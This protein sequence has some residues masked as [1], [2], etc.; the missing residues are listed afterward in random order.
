M[1][2]RLKTA[3]VS[4]IATL[5]LSS[6]ILFDGA[7]LAQF[8][9]HSDLASLVEHHAVSDPA[10]FIIDK[11]CANRIVMIA[12]GGHGDV[13]YDKVVV[14]ALNDWCSKFETAGKDRPKAL[15]TKLIL[16]LEMDSIRTSALYKYF[17]DGNPIET[18]EPMNLWGG[19]FTTSTLEFYSDLRA[20]KH[21]VEAFNAVYCTDAP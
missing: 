21:R 3:T 15:P 1:Q 4:R 6:C 7:L 17:L 5:V 12:D 13:P 16:F 18:V 9:R 19:P 11:L 2:I 10:R 14:D 8:D 20:L